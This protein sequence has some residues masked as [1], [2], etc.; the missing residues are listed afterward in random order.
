MQ[1]LPSMLNCFL[2]ATPNLAYRWAKTVQREGVCEKM[3]YLGTEALIPIELS[4]NPKRKLT[5]LNP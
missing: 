2:T 4:A 3:V 1:L 5:D